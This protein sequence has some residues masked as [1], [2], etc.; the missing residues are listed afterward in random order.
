MN[1]QTTLSADEQA[2]IDRA[3]KIAEQNDRFRKTWGADVSVPG[4]IIVTRAVASL[5]AGA[6]VQIMRAVQTFDTFT[7]DNDPYGDHTF[8]AFEAIEAGETVKLFW[9]IDLY[10]TEYTFGSAAPP[11]TPLRPAAS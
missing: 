7:E 4:Q 9:K 11:R 8:G 2:E 1:D 3:A 5:S 10:D 6:Q